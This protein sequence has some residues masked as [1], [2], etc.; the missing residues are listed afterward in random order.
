MGTLT[1]SGIRT[2]WVIAVAGIALSASA[3]G[4]DGGSD[5]A[6]GG[7][8]SGGDGGR[9]E[10]GGKGGSSPGGAAS[11]GAPTGGTNAKGGTSAG[12]GTASGGRKPIGGAPEG[13]SAGSPEGGA[14]QSTGGAPTGGP[15]AGAGAE[16]NG[17]TG[18]T[19]VI[20]IEGGSGGES[21]GAGG[22]SGNGGEEL[23]PYREPQWLGVCTPVDLSSDGKTVLA[24]RGLWTE[25]EG[26]VDLP[27]LPGGS[28]S[29]EPL[30]LSRDGLVVFGA[31]SSALG[32][33]LYRYSEATGIVGLGRIR[34]PESSFGT[35]QDGSVLV[36]WSRQNASGE[37][38]PFAWTLDGGFVDIDEPDCGLPDREFYSAYAANAG[39]PWL[40]AAGMGFDEYVP[41]HGYCRVSESGDPE[42][43]Y[44]AY[45]GNQE[46]VAVSSNGVRA[47]LD[48]DW[49]QGS[50]AEIVSLEGTPTA[51]SLGCVSPR[52]YGPIVDERCASI[53]SIV[54]D[55]DT[56]GAHGVGLEWSE[57]HPYAVT[58]WGSGGLARLSDAL[59]D[60]SGY[61]LV[62]E[63][64]NAQLS[65]DGTTVLAVAKRGPNS[66]CFLATTAGAPVEFPPPAAPA[67]GYG[68]PSGGCTG[69]A[70]A[71]GDGHTCALRVDG[72]VHCWGRGDS[73]QLGNGQ[74]HDARTP[75][76]VVGITSA[77]QLAATAQHTCALLDD[78]SVWCWGK[79]SR[80]QLGDGSLTNSSVPVQVT[81]PLDAIR[82]AAGEEHSCAI[83][84]DHTVRCWGRNAE[85]QLGNGTATDAATPATVSTLQNAVQIAAGSTGTCVVTTG[86]AAY[87]W[88]DN[89]TQTTLR[90]VG[91]SPALVSMNGGGVT[92]SGPSIVYSGGT[93]DNGRLEGS[94]HEWLGSGD[95]AVAELA[96]GGDLWC[97][98]LVN[99]S[100][101]CVAAKDRFSDDGGSLTL[102]TNAVQIAAG[103]AHACALHVDGTIECTGSR[104]SGALGDDRPFCPANPES[105]LHTFVVDAP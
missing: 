12:G 104:G 7:A 83:L 102:F 92:F 20:V 86:H 24:T 84:E 55:L 40:F 98:R 2:G 100:V 94:Y 1:K 50:S 68:C 97:L 52:L 78:G 90:D 25:A 28:V 54:T 36:G 4:D 61:C 89:Q 95:R 21:G 39:S 65:G 72:H 62:P 57:G 87:C 35:N 96:A 11:G 16:E 37:L 13:G 76:E 45:G 64:V 44:D 27:D 38:A 48:H 5:D 91:E 105:A 59:R 49:S 81:L 58:Y 41:K 80:G 33:E 74:T 17:T 85:R 42:S 88:G 19:G 99:G 6:S 22:E 93:Y 23:S 34:E 46:I 26:W 71:A 32:L 66:E 31:S 29:N 8:Q 43:P 82:V 69:G 67:T 47:C 18:G 75:V 77:V 15:H 51:S 14:P 3:C 10:S 30:A 70:I 9:A 60:R 103:K 63:F 101:G 73:G 53:H 56:T 79:N